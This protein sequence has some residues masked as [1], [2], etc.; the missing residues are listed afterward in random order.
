[1]FLS[2]LE[3]SIVST[4]LVA[5]T[6]DLRGFSQSS[7]IVTAYLLTF[8]GKHLLS[9][10]LS[11]SFLTLESGFMIVWAKLS[12]IYGR[13]L[14]LNVALSMFVVFSGG[15]GAAQTTTQVYE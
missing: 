5:I 3:V 4:S 7:W 13:K 11:G 9:Y 10:Q 8:S 2:N 12:D 14:L 15:C 1:M 6:D